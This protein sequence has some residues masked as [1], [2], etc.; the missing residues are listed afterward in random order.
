V[1][2]PAEDPLRAGAAELERGAWEPAR[3]A[4]EAAVALEGSPEAWEGLSWAAWWLEDGAAAIDAREHA[5]R[6]F[7]QAGDRHGAARMALWLFNDQVEFRRAYAVAGGWLERAAR[8]LDELE[9]APE[10][11]WLAAMQAYAELNSDPAAAQALGASARESGRRCGLV[12]LEMLGLATEG[13]ALVVAGDVGAG[14]RRL[15]E[16]ATAALAGEFEDHSCVGW[17]CCYLISACESVRDYDRAAQWSAQVERY[18]ARTR[19]R[20]LR[21]VCR[22]HHGVVLTWRG[23]LEEADVALTGA[24]RELSATRPFWA[25]EAV[26]RLGD[27]RRR[28]GRAAEARE[29]Y[30]RFEGEALACVG[31]AELALDAGD[32][33]G[34]GE[35]AARTLRRLPG[36][37][38]AA[39]APALDVLVRARAAVGDAAGAREAARELGETAAAIGTA[40]L[41]GAASHAE[42]VAAAVAGDDDGAR[43][44]FEDAVA[45]FRDADGP[46]E[47]GRARLALAGVLVRLGRADAARDAAAAALDAFEAAGARTYAA[48]AR[49]L[50]G[51]DTSPLTARE[52]EVLRLVADGHGNRAIAEALTISEHTVHRHVAN[53]YA[54]L[55]CSTRAAA[56]AEAGRLN[57]L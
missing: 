54:R 44:C 34:A 16:A 53:I 18:A 43:R 1:T 48:A 15:D 33:A 17:T 47:A 40:P 56:V 39:R 26:V 27:L 28:Q 4:F 2:T 42:G 49:E 37:C 3:A 41:L 46:V 14:M 35:L 13:R 32:A 21:G 24:V 50:L 30:E 8:I 57:L 55:G 7:Q 51:R 31:L 45:L 12:S 20:F 23:R 19:I 25:A 6:L 22:A 10:H 9:P 11:G 36:E 29:L 5:Y 52:R 38:R